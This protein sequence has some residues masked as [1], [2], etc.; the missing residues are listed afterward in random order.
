MGEFNG[1]PARCRN[2]SRGLTW[3]RLYPLSFLQ[4]PEFL[5]SRFLSSSDAPGLRRM[6]VRV[7]TILWFML[8][9][10]TTCDLVMPNARVQICALGPRFRRSK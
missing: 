10:T 2:P 7:T 9:V 5:P 3:G 1:I 6:L 8:S 4:T